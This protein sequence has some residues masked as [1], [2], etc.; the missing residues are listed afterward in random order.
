MGRFSEVFFYLADGSC[1]QP[2]ADHHRR[3]DGRY[4]VEET[5]FKNGESPRSFCGLIPHHDID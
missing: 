2:Y 5:V 4:E 1:I 3:V